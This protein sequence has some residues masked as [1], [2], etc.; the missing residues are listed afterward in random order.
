M[1]I[2]KMFLSFLVLFFL[3]STYGFTD[4]FPFDYPF[5]VIPPKRT[6]AKDYDQESSLSVPVLWGVKAFQVMISPQDGP[7]CIYSPTCSVYGH[8]VLRKYGFFWGTIMAADRWL[9]CNPFGVGG[10]DKPEDNFWF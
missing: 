3:S 7:N 6:L 2:N 5:L 4:F 9:R 8:Q 1:T 10:D